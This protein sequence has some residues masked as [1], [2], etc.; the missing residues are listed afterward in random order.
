MTDNVSIALIGAVATTAVGIFNGWVILKT[1]IQSKANGKTLDAVVEQ[2]N[3]IQGK[4]ME[5]AHQ[6]GMAAQRAQDSALT[7]PQS[8]T[9]PT[10][11]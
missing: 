6:E 7:K 9:K 11:T 3:G 10:S 1:H 8:P 5:A 2:T 4:L